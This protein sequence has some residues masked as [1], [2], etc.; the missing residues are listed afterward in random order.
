MRD[1]PKAN[2]LQLSLA[3]HRLGLPYPIAYR[4]M[5]AGELRGRRIGS[6]WYVLEKDVARLEAE[7]PA[8]V[9]QPA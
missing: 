7:G 8:A 1:L 2:E 5:F 4:R 3:A 6:R 9:A